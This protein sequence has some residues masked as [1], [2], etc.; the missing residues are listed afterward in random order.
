MVI[1][2]G[3]TRFVWSLIWNQ[4]VHHL[5]QRFVLVPWHWWT[6]GFK[7]KA[8]FQE[9]PWDWSPMVIVLLSFLISLV[10]KITLG[11]W[12]KITGKT[13]DYGLSMDIKIKGLSYEILIQAL[14]LRV[15]V[16]IFGEVDRNH[17]NFWNRLSHMRRND[18]QQNSK[19]VYRSV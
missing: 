2:E 14:N 5:W 1:P 9:L 10:M 18:Q 7:S 13:K 8:P 11:I 12:F 17:W 4:M 3:A 16:N 6:L 19:W 15:T